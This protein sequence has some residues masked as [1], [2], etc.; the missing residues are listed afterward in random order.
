MFKGT[1]HSKNKLSSRTT[2][3][4]PWN[5]K[6]EFFPS[7]EGERRFYYSLKVL[8]VALKI[9]IAPFEDIWHN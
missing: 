6:G 7:N 2:L 3:F 5:T 8:P 4:F 9:I 1:D